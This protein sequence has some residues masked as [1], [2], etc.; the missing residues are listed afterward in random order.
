[1]SEPQKVATCRYCSQ[2][3]TWHKDPVSGKSYPKNLNG[4][5]HLCKRNGT[6]APAAMPTQEQIAAEREAY[7]NKMQAAGFTTHN[8]APVTTEQEKKAPCTSPTTPAA[9]AFWSIPGVVETIDHAARKVTISDEAGN[10]TPL[11][12]AEGFLD[13]GFGNLKPGYF[14]EFGGETGSQRIASVKWIEG[15]MPAWVKAKYAALNPKTG[16]GG[17]RPYAPRNEK[18]M[19]YESAFKSCAELVRPDDFKGMDY[20]ARVEAVRVEAEKIAKWMIT[21]GGA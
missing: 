12:W 3:I 1:M 11:T 20:A 6:P 15:E 16:G 9:P 2:E 18:P 5:P 10:Q 8:P 14:R 21:N 17:G 19:I 13:K 7:N 4:S